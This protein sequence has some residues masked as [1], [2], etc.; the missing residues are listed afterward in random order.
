MWD[1][2]GPQGR[3]MDAQNNKQLFQT[4]FDFRKYFENEWKQ[5]QQIC[6]QIY[7]C[8]IEEKNAERLIINQKLK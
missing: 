5:N 7:Y 4:I 1:L 6:K 3:L 2:T 8:F